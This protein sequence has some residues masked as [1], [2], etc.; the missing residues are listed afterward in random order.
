MSYQFRYLSWKGQKQVEKASR[1][2]KTGNIGSK[3]VINFDLYEKLALIDNAMKAGYE[4]FTTKGE[5]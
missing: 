3:E 5:D 2:W 1:S 4:T